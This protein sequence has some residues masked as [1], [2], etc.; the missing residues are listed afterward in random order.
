MRTA[1]ATRED[2]NIEDLH[3]QIVYKLQRSKKLIREI[4]LLPHERELE[5]MLDDASEFGSGRGNHRYN[6]Q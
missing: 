1:N 2:F 5:Y 4:E 6:Q 3:S